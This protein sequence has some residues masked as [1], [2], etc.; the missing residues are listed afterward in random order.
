M[1]ATIDGVDEPDP[2]TSPTTKCMRGGRPGARA[3]NRKKTWRMRAIE[4]AD[5]Y[6]VFVI[7]MAM[8]KGHI[9]VLRCSK[10][11]TH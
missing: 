9:S 8:D 10:A 5:A 11:T 1:A 2:D 4:C 6:A 7:S 3:K